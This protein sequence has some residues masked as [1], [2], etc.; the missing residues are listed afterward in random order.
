MIRIFSYHY[1]QTEFI[2]PLTNAKLI[3]T[4]VHAPSLKEKLKLF[5]GILKSSGVSRD[6]K[7]QN[8]LACGLSLEVQALLRPRM[9]VKNDKENSF[10][11]NIFEPS[12]LLHSLFVD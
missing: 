8:L 5:I 10:R 12:D 4:L 2:I 7:F 6:I 1:L 9:A 11:E 3:G